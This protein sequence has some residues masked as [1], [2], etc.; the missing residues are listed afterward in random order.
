MIYKEPW[1]PCD[2]VYAARNYDYTIVDDIDINMARSLK[3]CK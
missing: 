3:K 1:L 2:S